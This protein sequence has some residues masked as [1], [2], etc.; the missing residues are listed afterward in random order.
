M[1]PTVVASIPANR[2]GVT[3]RCP[4][5]DTETQQTIKCDPA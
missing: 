4:K 3:Y 2:I 5:C 1:A